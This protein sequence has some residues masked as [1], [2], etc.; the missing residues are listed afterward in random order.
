M[1]R[2]GTRLARDNLAGG[3]R[4]RAAWNEGKALANR[5]EG[6]GLAHP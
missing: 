5:S 1:Q 4:V 2:R 6:Q 3:F